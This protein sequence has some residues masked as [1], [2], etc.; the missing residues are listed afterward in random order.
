MRISRQ[1]IREYL[2]VVTRPDHLAMGITRGA[3]LDDVATL[4]RHFEVL[5]DGPRVTRIL[6]GLCREVPVGGRRIHDANIVA[7]L[8]AHGK[9]RL[10]TFN[11]ADF[12]P[13]TR[14]IELVPG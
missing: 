1:I 13:Y 3:A 6:V 5:E 8:L 9:H 11:T 2:S 10:F 4:L 14:R 7:T 12:R